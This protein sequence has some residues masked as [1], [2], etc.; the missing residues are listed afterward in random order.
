MAKLLGP[1]CSPRAVQEQLKKL[2]KIGLQEAAAA[3]AGGGAE[4]VSPRKRAKP[5]ASK[6]PKKGKIVK[7]DPKEESKERFE[8]K[9]EEGDEDNEL[10][11]SS[12]AK[13]PR[14]K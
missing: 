7:D 13:R 4:A 10:I 1:N 9:V 11:M 5:V 6:E 12:P 3:A 8:R 14:T 2:K